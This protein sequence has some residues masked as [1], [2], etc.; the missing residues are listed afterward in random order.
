MVL[1]LSIPV[2]PVPMDWFVDI[3]VLFVRIT[4]YVSLVIISGIKTGREHPIT[5][6]APYEDY[7]FYFI[8]I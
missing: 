7:L 2:T 5:A 4:A 3:S 6:F 8:A 1:L